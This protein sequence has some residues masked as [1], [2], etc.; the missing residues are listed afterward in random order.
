MR[1]WDVPAGYLN[2]QSLL[3]EHRELH[4]IYSILTNGKPELRSPSGNRAGRRRSAA[5]FAPSSIDRG[6]AAARLRRSNSTALHAVQSEVAGII[7]D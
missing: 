2:R 6:N 1:I 3:G 4:G 7:R 5:G